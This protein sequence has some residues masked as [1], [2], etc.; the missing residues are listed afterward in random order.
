[1]K[2]KSLLVVISLALSLQAADRPAAISGA[3][4][5]GLAIVEELGPGFA[6]EGRINFWPNKNIIM[7]AQNKIILNF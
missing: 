2:I 1:M 3:F 4:G 7:V 5:G 6:G